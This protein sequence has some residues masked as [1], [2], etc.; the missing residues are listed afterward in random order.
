MPSKIPHAPASGRIGVDQDAIGKLIDEDL[1]KLSGDDYAAISDAAR[2]RFFKEFA[3]LADK[4]KEW[5]KEPFPPG[6]DPILFEQRQY[7]RILG[8]LARFW[9]R[10][11]GKDVA[12]KFGQLS[13]IFCGLSHGI[14]HPILNAR[15]FGNR[16]PD[17][18]DIWL[19]RARAVSGMEFLR[20]SGERPLTKAAST[21]ASEA[22]GLKRLLEDKAN[23]ASSLV[24]WRKT[25]RQGKIAKSRPWVHDFYEMNQR[26]IDCADQF[27]ISPKQLR[28]IGLKFLRNAERAALGL[29]FDAENLG[30]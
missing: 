26:L 25:L 7:A 20:R 14:R 13:A 2:A 11:I 12:E 1:N 21:A 27:Q 24:S 6:A 15:K 28:N 8:L 23:L 17:R 9:Q 4:L 22:P 30:K 18:S 5:V 3:D 29:V 16:P 10:C 19:I